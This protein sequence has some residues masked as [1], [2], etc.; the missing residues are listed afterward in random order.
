MVAPT[1]GTNAFLAVI[2]PVSSSNPASALLTEGASNTTISGAF[3][4]PNGP[5]TLS[6]GA[7][8]G[9]QA[10]QCLQIVASQISLS[11]GTSATASNCFS[12]SSGSSAVQLVQ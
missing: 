8:I 5:L 3:Y 6:G 2:G 7:S 1:T 11:G 4:F 12:G 10:G 9:N